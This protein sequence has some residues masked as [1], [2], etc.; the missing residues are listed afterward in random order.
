MYVLTDKARLVVLG[1]KRFVRGLVAF[2]AT[3][4]CDVNELMTMMVISIR[5]P[6]LLLA[7]AGILVFV[8]HGFVGCRHRLTAF[9]CVN[10]TSYS[11]N[12]FKLM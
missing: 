10:E 11:Q 5:K 6:P 3:L 12:K 2:M 8:I 9:T 7:C 4:V 1:I